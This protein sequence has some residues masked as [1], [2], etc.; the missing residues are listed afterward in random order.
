MVQEP[1]IGIT[2]IVIVIMSIMVIAAGYL[3][4]EKK[5]TVDTE[6]IIMNDAT[7]IYSLLVEIDSVEQGYAVYDRI[8]DRY[9]ISLDDTSLSVEVSTPKGV[10]KYRLNHKLKNVL[11]AKVKGAEALC[12]VKKIVNCKP[13][14]TLCAWDD[15]NCCN[16]GET[17]C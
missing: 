10:I 8:T 4:A 14:I 7:S 5:M 13:V 11:P 12:I 9:V 6:T 3:S 1:A 2:T 17:I 16:I 15:K